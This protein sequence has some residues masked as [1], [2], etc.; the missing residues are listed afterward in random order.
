[1]LKFLRISIVLICLTMLPTQCFASTLPDMLYYEYGDN[2]DP[3]I[4]Y[5]DGDM[6]VNGFSTSQY[7]LVLY[8]SPTCGSCVDTIRNANK[9][10]S[11]LGDD[12][13]NYLFIFEEEVPE[14]L[15]KKYQLPSEYV[16]MSA[17]HRLS[18]SVP[19]FFII[20]PNGDVFFKSIDF[21]SAIEKLFKMNLFNKDQLIS[22]ANSYLRSILPK[23]T[24]K[25]MVY[26]S[27]RGC[28]DCSE[29]DS[30]I[31][32]DS[33]ILDA[34]EMTS[35]GVIKNTHGELM[36]KPLNQL[37]NTPCYNTCNEY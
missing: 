5:L 11:I 20:D 15:I 12:L 16:A 33:N 4:V 30:L 37:A 14:N 10:M 9:V 21:S 2:F 26:F 18:Q 3:P 22:N 7:T 34:F 28:G 35:L 17:G 25:T 13:L 32:S 8:L 1:M 19:T 24:K 36:D 23:S 29:V 31:D 27:M 6:S